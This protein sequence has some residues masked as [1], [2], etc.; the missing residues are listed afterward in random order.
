MAIATVTSP[1]G[2]STIE[3]SSGTA[4]EVADRLA[5]LMPERPELRVLGFTGGTTCYIILTYLT[6]ARN[7]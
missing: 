4:Q 6:T 1:I 3:I 2:D 7:P 5:A